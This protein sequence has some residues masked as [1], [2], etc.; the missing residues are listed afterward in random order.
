[1]SLTYLPE[2]KLLLFSVK[3]MKERKNGKKKSRFIFTLPSPVNFLK[4][5]LFNFFFSDACFP[6]C[7]TSFSSTT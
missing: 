6:L 4:M 1:M 2:L 3:C 5:S 7:H